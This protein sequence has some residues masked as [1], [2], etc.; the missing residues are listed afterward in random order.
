MQQTLRALVDIAQSFG[1]KPSRTYEQLKERM[2]E[3]KYMIYSSIQVMDNEKYW[4]ILKTNHSLYEEAKEN[5]VDCSQEEIEH[6]LHGYAVNDCDSI[7]FKELY[8]IGYSSKL[9]YKLLEEE[10]WEIDRLIRGGRLKEN[11]LLT[12][13]MIIGELKGD[14]GTNKQRYYKKFGSKNY[15][16][17]K[18]M[19]SDIKKCL[20][21]NEI[22]LSGLNKALLDITELSKKITFQGKVSIYNPSNTLLSIYHTIASYDPNDE[23]CWMPKYELHING[24]GIQKLYFGCLVYNENSVDLKYVIEN[25]YDGNVSELIMSRIW[26]GY[27]CNDIDISLIYGLEYSNFMIDLNMSSSEPLFYKFDGYRYKPHPVMNPYDGIIHFLENKKTFVK[28]VVDLFEAHTLT[29][30]VVQF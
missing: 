12:D 6:F 14:S 9:A 21:N 23:M 25:G 30:G 20:V 5:S 13:E 29:S 11:E 24:D 10:A 26:G 4:D 19:S 15:S 17:L 8:D 18:Q 27:Q 2:P 7:P 22:W 28:D 16:S 3:Y 1:T